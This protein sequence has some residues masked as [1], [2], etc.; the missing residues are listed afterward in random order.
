MVDVGIQNIPFATIFL[1]MVIYFTIG[2]NWEN[3][4]RS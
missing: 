1:P 3:L 2:D 4:E